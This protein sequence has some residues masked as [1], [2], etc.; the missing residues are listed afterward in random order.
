MGNSEPV[1]PPGRKTRTNGGGFYPVGYSEKGR[2]DFPV[3]AF[4][5][6]SSRKR[7]VAE[8]CRGDSGGSAYSH[9]K[10]KCRVCIE[11][12]KVVE[13]SNAGYV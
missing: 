2:S 11:K 3:T 8:M 4:P 10:S 6:H 9:L 1:P 13:Q 5:S 7:P 12:E